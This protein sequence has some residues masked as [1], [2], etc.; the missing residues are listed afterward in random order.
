M[1]LDKHIIAQRRGSIMVVV[2]SFLQTPKYGYELAKLLED[3]GYVVDTNTLYPML[4]R[5]EK[6]KILSSEWNESNNRTQKYYVL[7]KEGFELWEFLCNEWKRTNNIIE[8]L[9]K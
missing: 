8:G 7:T 5:L 3:S 2:L 1:D 6:E 9:I 4:R